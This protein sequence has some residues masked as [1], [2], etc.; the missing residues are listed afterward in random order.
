MS[1]KKS[2]QKMKNCL[3]KIPLTK[4]KTLSIGQAKD[5]MGL[6]KILANDTRL[7]ILHSIASEKEMCVTE[8][9]EKLDMGIQAISNQLQRLVD[10]GILCSDRKGNQIFYSIDDPC[11]FI[12]LDKGLCLLEEN[13]ID[14]NQL[15]NARILNKT[16]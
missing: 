13:E 9:A 14:S 16:K 5:L 10:Q 7:R 15:G 1:T 3:P 2:H 6:F 4:R 11:I 8:I 12:L